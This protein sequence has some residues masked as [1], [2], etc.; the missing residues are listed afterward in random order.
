MIITMTNPIE[1]TSVVYIVVRY[2]NIIGVYSSMEN[3]AQ[4]V[5]AS[6]AK[7]QVCDMVIRPIL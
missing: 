4:V 3:A 1:K 5:S 7:G 2:G 6:I